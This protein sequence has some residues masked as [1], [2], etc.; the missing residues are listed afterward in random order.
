MPAV[1][2]KRENGGSPRIHV[3]ELGFQAERL[4][5]DYSP[6]ALAAGFRFPR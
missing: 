3:G 2:G 5:K 6:T 4:A 1:L